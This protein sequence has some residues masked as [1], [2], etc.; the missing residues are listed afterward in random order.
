[1]TD[2]SYFVR[3]PDYELIKLALLESAKES[4]LSSKAYHELL[5]IRKEKEAAIKRLKTEANT[6]ISLFEKLI[7]V[8]PH[9]S[10]MLKPASGTSSKKTASKK[11]TETKSTSSSSQQDTE[12]D[13]LNKALS[14]IE[15]KLEKL[16]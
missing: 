1:M 4:L 9:S 6:M 10:E 5:K 3:I 16:S 8:L 7:S 12:L 14:D 2:H 11:K 15:R 13:R